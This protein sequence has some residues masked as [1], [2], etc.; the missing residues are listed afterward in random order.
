MHDDQTGKTDGW[1]WPL[2]DDDTPMLSDPFKDKR[3]PAHTVHMETSR[4]RHILLRWDGTKEEAPDLP[5]D[6]PYRTVQMPETS[7]MGRGKG[8]WASK[9]T[10]GSSVI[11]DAQGNWVYLDNRPVPFDPTAYEEADQHPVLVQ[12]DDSAS[13]GQMS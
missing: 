2:D 12:K 10:D 1:M 8:G 7:P 6:M 5:S 4:V 13:E 3:E 9:L 11:Q